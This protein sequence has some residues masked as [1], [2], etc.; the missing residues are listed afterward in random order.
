MGFD[1][2]SPRLH[3]GPRPD[4]LAFTERP[5]AGWGPISRKDEEGESN[6]RM[7]RGLALELQ[8]DGIHVDGRCGAKNRRGLPCLC[9]PATERNSRCRFHGGLS[10]GPKTPETRARS[11]TAM[12]EGRRRWISARR[13]TAAM[14]AAEKG[15][16]RPVS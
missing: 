3:F 13:Q 1:R 5:R 15:S 10:T 12:Q 6:M 11:I 16:Q 4:L 2:P 14:I 8:R 9:K 7:S